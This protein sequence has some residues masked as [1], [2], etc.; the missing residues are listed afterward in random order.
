MFV[1][2]CCLEEQYEADLATKEKEFA[3]KEK[4]FKS[5]LAVAALEKKE[6]D[7]SDIV[8]GHYAASL[9]PLISKNAEKRQIL[10]EMALVP[11]RD[12]GKV[13]ISVRK[14]TNLSE[15]TKKFIVKE[16][17][18][19]NQAGTTFEWVLISTHKLKN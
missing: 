14:E 10:G 13:T 16:F 3:A 11:A 15:F 9:E 19:K 8:S 4:D 18:T 17:E 1:C 5:R 6:K 7:S 2:L 12:I